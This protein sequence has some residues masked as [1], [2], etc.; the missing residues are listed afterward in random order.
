MKTFLKQFLFQLRKPALVILLNENSHLLSQII[1]FLSTPEI[2]IGLGEPSLKTILTSKVLLLDFNRAQ[3]LKNWLKISQKPILIITHKTESSKET[4]ELLK[5][6]PD[7]GL[8]ILNQDEPILKESKEKKSFW[9]FSFGLQRGADL[10]I[11]D[12]SVDEGGTNFKMNYQGHSV[13]FW[14]E[15]I[16]QKETL[17]AVLAA[18]A[19]GLQFNLNLV[20]AS[21]KLKKFHF[22]QKSLEI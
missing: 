10:F 21:Q 20:N 14:L 8:V 18:I 6:F 9:T 16:H 1:L 19:L 2:K 3:N 11:S 13:P 17:Y 12:L 7:K 5:N 4:G 22:P 15:S